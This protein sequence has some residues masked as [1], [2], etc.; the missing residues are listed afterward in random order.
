MSGATSPSQMKKHWND[1]TKVLQLRDAGMFSNVNEVIDNI[2]YAEKYGC[3]FAVDWPDSSFEE[4]TMRIRNPWEYYFH[5]PYDLNIKDCTEPMTSVLGTEYEI[6]APKIN[7]DDAKIDIPEMLVPPKDRNRASETIEKRLE[8]KE[9]IKTEIDKFKEK[10][11]NNSIIG[12]HLRGPHR[13]HGSNYFRDLYETDRNVPF[14]KVFQVV[15]IRLNENPDS[16]IF[17]ASD[18]QFV[19]NKFKS[20][21]DNIITYDANRV[22]SSIWRGEVLLLNE[23]KKI[24]KGILIGENHTIS[25]ITDRFRVNNMSNY[26]L[27]RDVIVE[28]YLLSESDHF[29]HG[30]SNISNFVLCK[31]PN[32]PSDFIFKEDLKKYTKD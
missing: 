6:V 7:S 24:L 1:N 9:N 15:D 20:R 13:V 19:I 22:D 5:Q 12:V 8:V 29:V 28:A 4:P 21:Y 32:L 17:L 23:Y 3:T 16:S 31:N 14:K 2:I 26:E 30:C 10:N 18:S 11:F 25:D 27:G